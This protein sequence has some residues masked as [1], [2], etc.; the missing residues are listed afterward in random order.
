[1]YASIFGSAAVVVQ[2]FGANDNDNDDDANAFLGERSVVI[3]SMR[4]IRE[5]LDVDA[6]FD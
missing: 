1:M 4:K 6:L 5:L 3:A 2:V